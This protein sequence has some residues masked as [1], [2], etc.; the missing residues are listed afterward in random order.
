MKIQN[1]NTEELKQLQFLLNKMNPHHTL[2]DVDPVEKMIHDIMENFDWE[3][4]QRAMEFMDW[5]WAGE[6]VTV[7][8]LKESAKRLLNN[9]AEIRLS[10]YKT[11][12]WELGIICATG[13]LQATAFCNEAK[14]KI[15]ALDLKFVLAEW[16]EQIEHL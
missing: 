9:A 1:L 7:D 6:Y 16:D 15:I 2:F 3:K 11:E 14:T 5:R 12:H 8:M 4:T 10:D 13:G